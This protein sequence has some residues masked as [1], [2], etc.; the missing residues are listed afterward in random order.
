MKNFVVLY[1]SLMT[2]PG[3]IRN[4]SQLKITF[5]SIPFSAFW[6]R[7]SVVSVLISLISDTWSI[8]PHDIKLIFQWGKGH[9]TSLL[10]GPSGVGHALHYCTG[11]AHP[12]QNKLETWYTFSWLTFAYS[13][14]SLFSPIKINLYFLSA[15]FS[16]FRCLSIKREKDF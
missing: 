10:V 15:S 6:L 5:Q 9:R 13:P 2:Q 11:V 8:G 12:Y 7:S 16:L 3:H 4:Y 14:L 1:L